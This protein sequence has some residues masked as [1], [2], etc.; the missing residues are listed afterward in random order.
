MQVSETSVSI[1]GCTLHV[2]RAGSGTPILYLH[3]AQGIGKWGPCFDRLAEHHE[4]LIPDHPGFGA[5][6]PRGPVEEVADLAYVYLDFIEQQGLKDVHVV[7][8]C[9]GGWAAL[10]MAVRS[11][12]SVACLTL[13]NSAGIHVPGVL[14]GDFFMATSDRVHELLFADTKR[15]RA[16]LDDEIA[17]FDGA[18]FHANRVMAARLSWSPRL[19]DPKLERWL[20][21]IK[22]PTS[23]IWGDANKVLPLAYGEALAQKIPGAKFTVLN[24]CGH[25]AHLEQPVA[26]AGAVLAAR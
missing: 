10:E 25:L 16:L 6:Q 24:N 23:V 5:S 14:L 18:A 17:A 21:R 19:F 11:P 9:I 26:L 3:G 8:H 2:R 12:A 13:V 22:A 20:R 15:G 4:L 7:G 1:D